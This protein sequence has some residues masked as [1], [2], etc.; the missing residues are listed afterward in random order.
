MATTIKVNLPP[1]ADAERPAPPSSAPSAQSGDT[2]DRTGGSG[3]PRRNFVIPIVAVV[4]LIGAIWAVRAWHYSRRHQ[5][6]DDA[7]V[8]GHIIPVLAK[9]GGYVTSVRGEDNVPVKEGDTIVTIDNRDYT[10]K[11]AQSTANLAAAQAAVGGTSG[12]GPG[13][14]GGGQV[15]QAIAQ[16]RTAEGESAANDAQII[17]AQANYDK[18]TADLA[19]YQQLVDRQIISKQQ[20]DAAQ[21]TAD[22]AKAQ[23][24][25]AQKQAAASGA[26]VSGARAGV[27]L[28]EARLAAAQAERD[29]AALQL[30]YTAVTA[31]ATGVISRKQVEVGQLVQPGQT[32]FNIVADTGV[33]ITANYKE[34]QLNDIRVGQAVDF[35][36]DAY[37]GCTAHGQLE[38]LSAAT[39]AKFALLPPDNATGNFTKVVQ[40]VPV[41]IRITQGCGP[42]RPLRPGMS[43]NSHIVTK[44]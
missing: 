7:Q 1:D 23:L 35:T 22:A 9:V 29:N 33:Y 37:P 4:V 24:V 15:G 11:L 42:D 40:R 27:R 19:R 10:V 6:T 32:L 21:A 13:G 17:A 36:V 3:A 14:G 25:A 2:A 44:S 12:G 20:L 38:S 34:T 43:V 5:S 31:P 28:A 18:A 41:R 39:G 16:V 30:S 8:D 26:G